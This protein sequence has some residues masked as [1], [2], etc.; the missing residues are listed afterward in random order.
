MVVS[1]VICMFYVSVW[2]KSENGKK[3]SCFLLYPFSSE[4]LFLLFS[5]HFVKIDLLM[6]S[7]HLNLAASMGGGLFNAKQG[8]LSTMFQRAMS[9]C[10]MGWVGGLFWD[11]LMVGRGA[12]LHSR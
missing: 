7:V 8:R 2:V 11:Q 9:V 4:F 10:V 3:G 1:L 12:G 5:L 6:N